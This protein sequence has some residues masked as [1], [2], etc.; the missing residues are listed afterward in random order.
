MRYRCGG[1]VSVDLI[2]RG[3]V[4]GIGRTEDESGLADFGKR[5]LMAASAR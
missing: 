3:E 4:E 5:Q 1:A 2:C